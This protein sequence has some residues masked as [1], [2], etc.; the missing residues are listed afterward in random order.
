MPQVGEEHGHTGA[1]A[2]S[3]GRGQ[4]KGPVTYTRLAGAEGPTVCQVPAE[5]LVRHGFM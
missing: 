1:L 5:G 3:S 4:S 2:G